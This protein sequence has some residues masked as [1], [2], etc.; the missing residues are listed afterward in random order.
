MKL[1]KDIY[2]TIVI[3]ISIFL[4]F[5]DAYEFFQ[6]PVLDWNEFVITSFYI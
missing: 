1:T 6:Y 4:I 2:Y 3:F 5:M